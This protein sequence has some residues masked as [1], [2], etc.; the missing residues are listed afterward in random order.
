[1]T[2][3][4]TWR[5]H[6]AVGPNP[7][8]MPGVYT[9]A[10]DSHA[11]TSALGAIAFGLFACGTTAVPPV[12]PPAAHEGAM[13]AGPPQAVPS[14]I[15]FE[16]LEGPYWVA[17]DGTLIFSDVVEKNGPA[18]KI[19]RYAP[20]SRAFSTVPYPGSP[21]STNGL[22]V[23][24][25]GRLLA[26]ERWN[27]VLARVARGERRT[28]AERAPDGQALNAPNDLTVRRDGNIYFSDT[29]WGARP[30]A[31]APTAVYRVSP[32]GAVSVAFRVDMPNGVLLSPDG[33]TLYVGSDAQD[34]LWRLPVAADGSVGAA[35][36]FGDGKDDPRARVHVPD[37]LC[38]DDGG[39]VY[40]TNNSTETSAIVV[41][42]SAGHFVERIP[43][44]APPSNCTFGG[45]D[46][47]TLYVTTLHALYEVPMTTPGLP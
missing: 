7:C 17:S 41:L 29:T 18:A 13:A 19:Y 5:E 42:D 2:T 8:Y 27:G 44:P 21:V 26:C 34:R 3:T 24:A 47:R 46:R 35:E 45:T 25:E 32:D 28:L 4:T 15:P 30:G 6:A 14:D 1:M 12:T 23:D 37:G 22:A 38:V 10:I 20:S 39:R 33:N 11:R 36:P 16:S 40:V 43:F 9:H 31:H